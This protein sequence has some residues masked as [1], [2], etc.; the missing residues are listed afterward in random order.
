MTNPLDKCLAPLHKLAQMSRKQLV[1][2][3]MLTACAP[4]MIR[5]ISH[6]LLGLQGTPPDYGF[7]IL[8]A[9]LFGASCELQRLSSVVL[10]LLERI[11]KLE[12]KDR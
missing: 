1:I 4:T 6:D 12:A 7:F 9:L 10:N 11:S 5:F 8:L 2:G 3:L